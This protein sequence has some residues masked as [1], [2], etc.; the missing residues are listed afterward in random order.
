MILLLWFGG[1]FMMLGT[2]SHHTDYLFPCSDS[3]IHDCAVVGRC[4]GC[5]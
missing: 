1:G 5:V 4:S 3:E 2:A